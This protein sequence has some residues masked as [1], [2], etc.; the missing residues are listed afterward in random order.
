M[1]LLFNNIAVCEE[2][3]GGKVYLD[4]WEN[5]ST[6]SKFIVGKFFNEFN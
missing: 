5:Q 3:Y 1:S 6:N 2:C 4:H